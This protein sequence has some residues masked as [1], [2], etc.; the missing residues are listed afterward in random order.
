MKIGLT[1]FATANLLL[2]LLCAIAWWNSVRHYRDIRKVVKL[3]RNR[4]VTLPPHPLALFSEAEMLALS[5]SRIRSTV[6]LT[7][8]PYPWSESIPVA[9][10]LLPIYANR[11]RTLTDASHLVADI[12]LIA[13]TATFGI[14]I[15]NPP[16]PGTTSA[17]SFLLPISLAFIAFITMAKRWIIPEW[18]AASNKYGE[19][20]MRPE[21]N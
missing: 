6:F 10:Y 20:S 9:P 21:S 8:T 18:R 1:A 11:L 14:A 12:A 17:A 15:T 2:L 19:L 7:K 13:A 4:I 3:R 5:N 16:E